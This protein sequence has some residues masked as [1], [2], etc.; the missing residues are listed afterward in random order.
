[1]HEHNTFCFMVHDDSVFAYL[2]MRSF[3][4]IEFN[5]RSLFADFE[6]FGF[7]GTNGAAL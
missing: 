3:Y 4:S 7:V 2:L 5:L 1:M 6:M